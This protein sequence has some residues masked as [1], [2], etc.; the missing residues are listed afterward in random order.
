MGYHFIGLGGI[1]MSAL[2]RIALQKGEKV[3]GSDAKKSALLKNLEKEGASVQIGHKGSL[4][5]TAKAVIYSSGI[6]PNNEEYLYAKKRRLPLYHRSDFLALLMEGKTQIAVAG[7]HGKTTTSALLAYVLIE[8]GLDPSFAVGGQSPSLKTNGRYGL[9]KYFLA[10]ADESDGSFLKHF[11]EYAILT[12]LSDDHLDY[13]GTSQALDR[14]F[15]QFI[16]QSKNLFWCIDEERLRALK[17]KGTSYG[18]SK[19]AD[20]RIENFQQSQKGVSFDLG[21]FSKIE[22][23]L[24]GRHN[25]NNSAAAFL[26]GIKLGVPEGILRSSLRSFQGTKRRLEFRKEV[27]KIALF[28]DY[29]HHPKEIAATI[30]AIRGIIG[31]KRLIVCFQA[32][33]FSRVRDH[34]F[35]FPRAFEGADVI[36]LTDIYAAGE[37]PIEGISTEALFQTFREKWGKKAHFFPRGQ[38]E[39]KL[40]AL[41]RPHDVVLLLG[42]GDITQAADLI[43]Q[44]VEK[45][46]K[47]LKVGLIYGGISQENAVSKLSFA[48][49]LSLLDPEIY[50]AFSYNIT[51]KGAWESNG[52]TLR[53]E[54]LVKKLLRC[55]ICIPVMH[56]PKGEDGMIAAFLETLGIAYVGCP[57]TSG[58]L[59]MNKVLSKRILLTHEIPVA[60]FYELHYSFYREKDLG[61]IE[62]QIPYPVWVKPSHLGSSIGVRRAMGFKELKEAIEEAFALDEEVIV[63]GEVLG[64]QVEFGVLGNGVDLRVQHAEIVSFGKFVGFEE[65]YGAQAMG[66][67]T[68]ANLSQK[69]EEEGIALAKK[70]YRALG[71]KGL[72]RIDFFLRPD[73]GF[74]FNEINPFPGFTKTSAFPKMWEKRGLKSLLDEMIWLGLQQSR[75]SKGL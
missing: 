31:G 7:T 56:G 52:K 44:G 39:K 60:P 25:A 37:E 63:E 43:L 50:E 8:A 19:E 3:Q 73:G 75:E 70:V 28:D 12:S 23:S 48:R 6:A 21:P 67:K 55:D 9:S 27:R 22:V 33:R 15:L 2:A 41:L 65:K 58:A 24:F 32:H 53:F 36:A 71:C 51:S 26:L 61:E 4:I 18:F 29:A 16:R 17:P 13:W 42:A 45:A 68:P 64:R 35:S 54:E 59:C 57:F 14:G 1:G 20:F 74:V 10:E 66:I 34:F 40:V 46:Q 49:I 11:S 47:K 72:S 62:R 69:E 5:K 38:L 30:E